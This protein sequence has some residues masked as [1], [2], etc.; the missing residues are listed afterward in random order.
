MHLL[1]LNFHAVVGY[2]IGID[3]QYTLSVGDGP[4]FL[5]ISTAPPLAMRQKF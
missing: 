5:T 3:A 1:N 2:F 4:W